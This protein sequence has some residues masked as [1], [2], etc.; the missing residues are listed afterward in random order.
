MADLQ[1]AASVTAVIICHVKA[2]IPTVQLRRHE[3]RR[4]A[5]LAAVRSALFGLHSNT[6]EQSPAIFDGS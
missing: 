5:T 1:A 2:D 4:G 3:I 6:K